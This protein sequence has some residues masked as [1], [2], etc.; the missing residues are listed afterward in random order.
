MRGVRRAHGCKPETTGG[1]HV[2]V[3]DERETVAARRRTTRT[4]RGSGGV[5]WGLSSEVAK[6]RRSKCQAHANP[7]LVVARELRVLV[8]DAETRRRVGISRTT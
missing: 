6:E 7:T 4:V 1:C 5:A 2:A 8:A 3:R